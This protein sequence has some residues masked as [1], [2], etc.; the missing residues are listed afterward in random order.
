MSFAWLL[1]MTLVAPGYLAQDTQ[2]AELAQVEP[3]AK[4]LLEAFRSG[5]APAMKP[6][7]ADS[8]MFVG[9]LAFLGDPKGTRGQRDVT[10][11]QLTSAYSAL[12]GAIGRDKWAGLIK[13]TKQTLIR[14]AQGGGHPDDSKGELPKG[15]VRAG[16][17]V[18]Q[19]SFPGSG[20]DDLIL[21]VLRPAAGKWQIVAHWADY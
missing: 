10:R 12:F 21:F 18:Y 8:V 4:K 3:I 20:M 15:F 9:D 16:D 5:D 6:L 19:I 14:A 7:F 17:Y 13:D 2:A 11:D 1:V